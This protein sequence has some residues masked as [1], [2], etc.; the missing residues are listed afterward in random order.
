MRSSGKGRQIPLYINGMRI[1]KMLIINI[2]RVKLD[3]V[4]Y[5]INYGTITIEEENLK[6]LQ[7][8]LHAYISASDLIT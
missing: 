6:W 4:L 1:R 8:Y 5:L 2:Y 3:H 7:A